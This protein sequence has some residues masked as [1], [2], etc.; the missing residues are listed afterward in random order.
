[1]V[2]EA[3]VFIVADGM[4]GHAAGEVASEMAVSIV[5]HAL[6]NVAGQP[7]VEAAE[8]IRKSIIEA[9]CQI[10]QRTL[11]EQDKRQH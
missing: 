9:N 10:F 11:V 5:G 7:D 8:V 2:P 6:E 4:G 1:M 3:G